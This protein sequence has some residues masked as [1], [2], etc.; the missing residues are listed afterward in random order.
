MRIL[1]IGIYRHEINNISAKNNPMHSSYD[2]ARGLGHC[3]SIMRTLQSRIDFFTF[4]RRFVS[5]N[6][7]DALRARNDQNQQT[8]HQ[9]LLSRLR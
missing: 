6:E 5:E 9:T 4:V 2:N 8:R 1:D 7:N 3:G